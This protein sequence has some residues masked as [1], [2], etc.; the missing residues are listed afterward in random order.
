LCLIKGILDGQLSRLP[1][2]G[3]LQ[4]WIICPVEPFARVDIQICRKYYL[5]WQG[6]PDDHP[7]IVKLGD[8]LEVIGCG[9]PSNVGKRENHG[10]IWLDGAICGR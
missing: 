5:C 1:I 6:Q 4:G 7:R 9:Q 8:E 10:I 3:A 2:Y